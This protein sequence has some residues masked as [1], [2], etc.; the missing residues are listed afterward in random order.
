MNK[1]ILDHEIERRKS[2]IFEKIQVNLVHI[3]SLQ[4]PFSVD[5]DINDLLRDMLSLNEVN[6]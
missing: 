3:L 5:T 2:L 1:E 6:N 4:S